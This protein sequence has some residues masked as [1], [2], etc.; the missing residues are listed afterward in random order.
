MK[1]YLLI[2]LIFIFYSTASSQTFTNV[3]L[4]FLGLT[5]SHMTWG[6][7][8]NDDDFD[9]IYIGFDV[10]NFNYVTRLYKNNGNGN[11][12]EINTNLPQL[13][14]GQCDWF[15]YDN[16]GDV[17]LG[18]GGLDSGTGNYY[19]VYRNQGSGAFVVSDIVSNTNPAM[20]DFDMDGDI[21]M[22]SSAYYMDFLI[23]DGNGNMSSYWDLQSGDGNRAV[24]ADVNGDGLTDILTYYDGTYND[25]T[26]GFFINQGNYQFTES[27]SEL[28][29]LKHAA[30][31]WGDFDDDGDPDLILSGENINGN[32]RTL[33]YE[34]LA[35]NMIL[36]NDS[37]P[38]QTGGII[39]T[40]DFDNDG[41][42]DIAL[43]G[44]Q[45][46]YDDDL[47]IAWNLGGFVFEMSNLICSYENEGYFNIVDYDNDG[48]VDISVN[49][50]YGI[51]LYRNDAISSNSQPGV[52]SNVTAS[53]QDGK[54][55]IHWVDAADAETSSN[56]LS[57]NIALS[58]QSTG[59]LLI[60]P[61]SNLANGKRMVLGVGNADYTH[62]KLYDIN[63][64]EIG[65]CEVRMQ[66][67][68]HSFVGSAFT[69]PVS[70]LIPPTSTFK[71][72]K[73]NLAKGD[74]LLVTYTGNGSL[75]ALY[76]W[77]FGVA[78]VV[79]G[80]GAGPFKL[81][82]DQSGIHPISLSISESGQI[83]DTTSLD[84]S[85]LQ[86]FAIHAPIDTS[87]NNAEALWADIDNDDD[88]DLLYY[89]TQDLSDFVVR[90]YRNEGNNQFNEVNHNIPVCHSGHLQWGDYNLD[91]NLDLLQVCVDSMNNSQI[92][93]LTGNGSGQFQEI[94]HDLVNGY[95]KEAFWA[96][97][98]FD[99]DVDIVLSYKWMGQRII[100]VYRNEGNNSFQ[101]M[102]ESCNGY[103][104]CKFFDY[105]NDHDL[106]VLMGGY[107]LE[108]DGECGFSNV[109]GV[110]EFYAE[111]ACWG[112]FNS[113]GLM[114]LFLIYAEWGVATGTCIFLNLGN[115][116][117]NKVPVDL[118]Y[119][120]YGS[121]CDIG[122]FD[123]DGDADI[124]LGDADIPGE[125][126]RCRVYDN[127]GN[128][129]FEEKLFDFPITHGETVQW[130]DY[131]NDGDLDINLYVRTGMVNTY[132]YLYENEID[133]PNT[134]PET[135]LNLFSS[136][137]SDTILNLLWDIATDAES[138]SEQLSYNL[139]LY[140]N[141]GDT[142]IS[143]LSN[144]SSGK[145]KIGGYGNMGFMNT[146]EIILDQ[147]GEYKWMVQA[148]DNNFDGSL[149]SA[150]QTITVGIKEVDRT[151]FELACE[152][153][154]FSDQM[155][156]K[157]RLDRGAQVRMELYNQEGKLV[158]LLAERYF[159]NGMHHVRFAGAK[160]TDG[161]F[162]LK[163]ICNSH[164]DVQRIIKL[165]K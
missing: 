55:K 26:T 60:S 84:V 86:S 6:D 97:L 126:Y 100:K 14:D 62:P 98:E 10:M 43:S 74:T 141:G 155:S 118:A 79:N 124:L 41:D 49:S 65:V 142:I 72:D 16:D 129:Q 21:D 75:S 134:K 2:L 51:A 61:Q 117:F 20:A 12:V 22:L 157:F 94:Y 99:G 149:F 111:S 104:P 54:L 164:I 58:H 128:L 1:N 31:A 45:G 66:T 89:G 13:Y 136:I 70:V 92:R 8:D 90:L 53:I 115:G 127:L 139:C 108:N 82:Y 57:Y 160:H 3:N 85:V 11:F 106:D 29:Q 35:G 153:N 143:A 67:V 113:D 123:H 5:E 30:A 71:T 42:L 145:K 48:D 112:D 15:D 52:P 116:D 105:D 161:V 95:A 91:N 144:L 50:V 77:E 96:D 28:M 47:F 158:D 93:I 17:D 87:L 138:L 34:N 163:L 131:D 130:V 146:A 152:P 38:G 165:S 59:N 32:S 80:S 7:F 121:S 140:R 147:A 78:N 56:G 36:I 110:S 68:D 125:P 102:P 39:H 119:S 88:M 19:R 83:S 76:S 150:E 151:P 133:V 33:I 81:I 4:P 162:I 137:D 63:D 18:L 103:A 107:L 132:F 23:N 46:S 156:V 27:G 37:L 9:L 114:D 159:D 69:A 73:S 24:C 44:E 122:D 40:A 135:P 25:P 148:V 64:F 109:A 120:Y 101:L 154:P